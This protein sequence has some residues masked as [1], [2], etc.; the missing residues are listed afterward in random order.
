M[1]IDVREINF[2]K[3][4]EIIT[5]PMNFLYFYFTFILDFEWDNELI[6]VC[7]YPVYTEW[8]F[9]DFIYLW[10]HIKS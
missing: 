8:Y 6:V 7:H 1:Y 5:K 9:K 10:L 4:F 3:G 2:L